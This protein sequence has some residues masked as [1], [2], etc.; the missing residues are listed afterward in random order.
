MMQHSAASPRTNG[1]TGPT[2]PDPTIDNGVQKPYHR[3]S[4]GGSDGSQL[5]AIDSARVEKFQRHA[6]KMLRESREASVKENN[7][8]V[9]RDR[10]K[11]QIIVNGDSPSHNTS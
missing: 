10:K 2:E 8:K 1:L 3:K 11:L 4:S 7:S 5:S 9:I 6:Q